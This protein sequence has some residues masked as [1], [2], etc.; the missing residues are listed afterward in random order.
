M[1]SGENERSFSAVKPN[2][3]RLRQNLSWN[4]LRNVL[5]VRYAG[6]SV[7]SLGAMIDLTKARPRLYRF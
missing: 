6:S 4:N 1:S 7:D 5:T 2:T 3:T